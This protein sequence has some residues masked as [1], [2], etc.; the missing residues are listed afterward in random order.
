MP[1]GSLNG[2]WSYPDATPV[3]GPFV[4]TS[5]I[6][7]TYMKDQ[8]W[9]TQKPPFRQR[10]AYISRSANVTKMG[11]SGFTATK[12][13]NEA[14]TIQ[15]PLAVLAKDLAYKKFRD[16]LGD[17][18]QLAA[19]YAEREKSVQM[20]AKRG[21][22]LTDFVRSLKHGDFT[23]A[24]R[25]IGLLEHVKYPKSWQQ[26]SKNF[27]SLFL[28]AHLGWEPLVKD[29]YNACDVLQRPVPA[30]RITGYGRADGQKQITLQTT[31]Y[32]TQYGSTQEYRF[33][34]VG[35]RL[36]ADV[37][38]DNPN[39]WLANQ[40]GLINPAAWIWELA[41]LSFVVDWFVTVG[42]FLGSL[43][44]FAGLKLIEPTTTYFQTRRT[45]RDTP[46]YGQ[47]SAGECVRVERVKGISTPGLDV[48]PFKGF[49]PIR[50]LTAVSLLTQ[51][52][53]S[54]VKK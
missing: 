27:G 36:L 39:L 44:D 21:R 52:L 28:E 35:V 18:S 9:Y 24:G 4:K 30:L 23:R 53:T 33:D 16:A 26:R 38:V 2:H 11:V 19:N 43:T 6:G 13:L 41:T 49:S 31:G 25:L 42:D 5:S 3:S 8:T 1:L 10:L 47:Y 45:Y 46:T 50:G 40:L 32:P 34:H 17:S 37:Y 22:Q 54:S 51:A 48:R 20:I 7:Q 14:P 12:L 15:D 29:I